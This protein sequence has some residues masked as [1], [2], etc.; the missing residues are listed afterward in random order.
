[1]NEI[2]WTKVKKLSPSEFSENPKH[3]EP[4]LIYSLSDTR[5]AIDQKIYP[6]PVKGALARFTGRTT[7]Q[8][9]AVNRLSKACDVFC[10]G[11]PIQNFTTILS[12]NKFMGMGIYIDTTG[13][14]GLPWIMFHLDIRTDGFA[15]NIPL[16]WIAEKVWSS[17]ERK[18]VTKYRHP[19]YKP[20]YWKLLKNE[21]WYYNRT[22]Q[23]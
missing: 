8:H 15:P 5:I 20:E 7:T 10:E 22:K 4:E 18:R 11:P 16:I 14:D 13:P 21:S 6:S 9:Y 17:T 12:L 23:R 2:D 19:Q 1:M 3:A